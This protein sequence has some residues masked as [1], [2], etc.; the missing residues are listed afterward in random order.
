MALTT[1]I[2]TA[3][4]ENGLT[5]LVKEIHTVPVATVWVWYKVGSRNEREG[6]TGCSHWVEHMLFKGGKR[7]GKGEIFG[8]V[9]K[10]GGYNNGFTSN[11]FTVYFETLP[12]SAVELGMDIEADRMANSLFDP[13]ETASERTVIISEREGAENQNE[14]LLSEE[15]N[16]AAFRVHP[17]RWPVVG[18]KC[19]L[20][21]MTREDLYEYYR[22][23]YGPNNAILVVAGDVRADDVMRNA[24]RLFGEINSQATP[25]KLRAVE[26]PQQGER[27]IWLRRP[28]PTAFLQVGYHIPAIGHDDTTALIMLD[29]ILSGA[30]GVSIMGSAW[31]GRSS[32]L[33]RALVETNLAT[34]AD[35]Y[36]PFSPDPSLFM[37]S[38]TARN[39][40][41]PERV[42]E[43]L[44]SELARIALEPPTED[45]L[46]KAVRQTRAQ[47]AYGTD[48]VTAQASILGYFSCIATPDYAD[49]IQDRLAEV[50]PEDVQ[51]V[52]A[53]YLQAD[54]RT[55]GWFIP[56]G[57]TLEGGAEQSASTG[58]FHVAC[59]TG[60][61]PDISS[62]EGR[63]TVDTTGTR[64][65]VER[66]KLSGGG[67]LLVCPNPHSQAVS[68][69]GSI[70]AGAIRE[71]K[72]VGGVSHMVSAMVMRGTQSMT[73]QEIAETVESL[74][75]S[76]SFSASLET[77][78]CEAKCLSTELP[79]MIKIMADCWRNPIFPE[80]ELEK[81]RAQTL[82]AIGER[83]DDTRTVA[84]LTCRRML[85]GI[86]HP[87]GRD[88]LGT[89]DTVEAL[90]RDLLTGFHTLWY[91][92][93]DL[94]LVVVGNVD[95]KATL[96]LIETAFADWEKS[97]GTANEALLSILPSREAV[98]RAAIVMAH[99]SQ[100][101][102]AIGFPAVA[103]S[104]PDYYAVDTACNILGRL[105]LYGRMGRSVRDEQGLAYYA[106]TRLNAWT[107]GGHWS[108]QAGVNPRNV[109][110]AR[111]SMIAEMARIA[112]EPVT[113]DELTDARNN[114]IGALAL[115][116]ETNDG[117]ATML[118]EMEYHGLGLDYLERYPDTINA[119]TRD[120]LLA[121]SHKYLVPE[122]RV[123]VVSGPAIR[124]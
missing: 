27:R 90:T 12:S 74:G 56:T 101:D 43:A 40:V 45:E 11:D 98:E 67:T 3:I 23:Y 22:T 60:G 75:A 42:E 83:D 87:Y 111:E 16:A 124:G 85:Y 106:F 76:L 53:Q 121:A 110:Q 113:E 35:S 112:A 105:G 122:R 59:A 55:V 34:S 81:V 1:G 13:A 37:F 109:E 7:F 50:K 51:R 5:V 80:S 117:V 120:D 108:A 30:K 46:A 28:G 64:L 70:P 36:C 89:R 47:F 54:N 65:P 102:I 97:S 25:P 118:H 10:L 14:Y 86:D 94:I 20:E 33:Y 52:A 116:L 62:G 63:V 17:Y 104:A 4:L 88:G 6:I 99:K 123:E 44:Q 2:Q 91:G 79:L 84:E 69:R 19:D 96:S 82:T 21:Q 71:L 95:P 115:R 77:A 119:L 61:N 103:R 66:F 32:R 18:F 57:G 24:E 15:L 114:Q 29:S 41:E 48:G 26:P 58:I 100:S 8:Q 9:A 73:Y 93:D 49:M 78:H 92:P 68:I 72:E 31:M 107:Y 39:S 38:V